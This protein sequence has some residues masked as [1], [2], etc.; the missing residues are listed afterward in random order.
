MSISKIV[1]ALVERGEEELANELLGQGPQR[2]GRGPGGGPRDGSGPNPNCPLKNDE[3]DEER[4]EEGDEAEAA[5]PTGKPQK[6]ILEYVKKAGGPVELTEMASDPMFRGMNFGKLQKSAEVLDKLGLIKFDGKQMAKA[7]LTD[8][9]IDAA[10]DEATAAAMRQGFEE[11][12]TVKDLEVILSNTAR[13][14]DIKTTLKPAAM[15]APIKKLMGAK[16]AWYYIEGKGEADNDYA[17]VYGLAI[18]RYILT[19]GIQTA[20]LA[21]TCRTKAELVDKLNKGMP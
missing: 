21:G 8:E 10:L 17:I 2:N 4:E 16:F 11:D 13:H 6:L 12:M 18:N 14:L 3:E 1:A 20:K 9:D 5:S 19:C 15:P 7:G